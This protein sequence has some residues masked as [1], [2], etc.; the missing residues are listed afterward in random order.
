M[1]NVRDKSFKIVIKKW[2]KLNWSWLNFSF[3]CELM[4]VSFFV[5]APQSGY[6]IWRSLVIHIVLATTIFF[7]KTGIFGDPK[8]CIIKE[9]NGSFISSIFPRDTATTRY[10]SVIFMTFNKIRHISSSFDGFFSSNQ[11][12]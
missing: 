12:I 1:N 8:L 4:S 7:N 6:N 5:A 2:L 11:S 9:P 10:V 3:N